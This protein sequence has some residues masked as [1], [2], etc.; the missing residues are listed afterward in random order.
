MVCRLPCFVCMGVRIP[1]GEMPESLDSR[2]HGR[3]R[4]Y[5]R[6]G[7]IYIPEALHVK[8]CGCDTLERTS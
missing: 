7:L 1:R 2:A 3:R 4:S 6:I 5:P 8:I